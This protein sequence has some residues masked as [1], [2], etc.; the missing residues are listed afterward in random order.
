MF[1]HKCG[2]QLPADAVF[3]SKCGTAVAVMT[4]KK[5]PSAPVLAPTGATSMKCP[6]CGAP[7]APKF[8]EM[9]ITCDYCGS[10]V[11]LGSEGWVGIRKQTML[12]L[13]YSDKDKVMQEMRGIMDRGL[14]HRHLME[15]STVEDMNLSFVPYW[16]VSASA[17]TSITATSMAAEGAEIATTAA[18]IGVMGGGFGGRRR[19]FG[20][21][22]LAGAMMG[23]MMGGGMGA[24]ATQSYELDNNY[25]F[26]IVSLK[27][28]SEYQPKSYEFR[29]DQRE[30]FDVAKVPKGVKILNG[31][32]GEDAAMYQAKTLVSQLQNEQAHEQYQMIQQLHTDVDVAETELLYAPIWFARYN[33]KGQ[34]IIVVIDANSSGIIN[35]IGI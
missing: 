24:G 27:A 28:L 16:I 8:G 10:G 12:P 22:V 15:D 9:V 17:K 19:G 23:G 13:V 5:T 25:N 2:A 34:K 29:L 35:T 4:V 6:N 18:L 3:C 14:F 26:P 30:L 21:P 1:C 33:H 31:D 20:G 7:I 11:T 32:I